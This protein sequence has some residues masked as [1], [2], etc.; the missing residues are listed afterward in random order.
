MH[1]VWCTTPTPYINKDYALVITTCIHFSKR[2]VSLKFSSRDEIFPFHWCTNTWSDG[3]ITVCYVSTCCA[4]LIDT[5][6][7]LFHVCAVPLKISTSCGDILYTLVHK[8]I[9]FVKPSKAHN[10]FCGF[11]AIMFGGIMKKDGKAGTPPWKRRSAIKK[12]RHVC[13]RWEKNTPNIVTW[14]DLKLLHLV[15]LHSK[16]PIKAKNV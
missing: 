11:D 1:L 6:W 10:F 13:K 4:L 5:T 7:S 3:A 12:T 16:S 2:T 9:T 15:I 14:N 8:T